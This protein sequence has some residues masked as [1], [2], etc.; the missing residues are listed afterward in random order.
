MKFTSQLIV[1]SVVPFAHAF[2]ALMYEAAVVDPDLEARAKDLANMLEARQAGAG[3]AT[4]LL[5]RFQR[6]TQRSS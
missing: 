4:A 1:A 2:P 6:L 5:H 3:A